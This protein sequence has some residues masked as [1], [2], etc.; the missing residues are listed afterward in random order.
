ME[1]FQQQRLNWIQRQYKMNPRHYKARKPFWC[2]K[3]LIGGC[4]SAP[5]IWREWLGPEYGTV[6]TTGDRSSGYTFVRMR[7]RPWI[8]HRDRLIMTRRGKWLLHKRCN[9]KDCC[10]PGSGVHQFVRHY[11]GHL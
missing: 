6:F 7:I 10:G 4:G 8:D 5:D 9:D 2:G 1:R 3:K 11:V